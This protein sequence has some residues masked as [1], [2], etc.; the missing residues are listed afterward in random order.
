MG[1]NLEVGCSFLYSLRQLTVITCYEP[2]PL[3]VGNVPLLYVLDEQSSVYL[4][5]KKKVSVKDYFKTS[6]ET[7]K[8]KPC[9]MIHSLKNLVYGKKKK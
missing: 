5:E 7:E 2:I 8:L 9:L 6:S 1:N 4:K 3:Y